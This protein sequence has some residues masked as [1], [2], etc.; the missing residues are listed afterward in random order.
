M[1]GRKDV[2]FVFR[3]KLLRLIKCHFQR[4]KVRLQEHV[5]SNDFIFQFRMLALM[6]GVPGSAHVKP[7]PAVKA[8]ILNMS[9]VVRNEVVAQRIAFVYRAPEISSLR[10]NSNTHGIADA[11]RVDAEARAVRVVFQNVGAVQFA[12]IIIHVV[13]V[14]P[15]SYG[16][17]HLLAIAGKS[18]IARPVS[19][20]S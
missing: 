13:V 2:A 5:G 18:D 10:L 6:L 15:R 11:R 4:S 16:D 7:G 14:R 12:G 17:I 1:F 9:D 8:S 19:T 3:G 20:A